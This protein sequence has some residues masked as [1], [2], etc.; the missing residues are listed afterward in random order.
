MNRH[1]F[2]RFLHIKNNSIVPFDEKNKGN[3][4]GGKVYFLTFGGQ[5]ISNPKFNSRNNVNYFKAVERICK[6]AKEF[7]IFYKIIGL[8]ESY[9]KEDNTF[10]NNHN[11]FILQNERGYGLWIWK[12]YIIKK[13]LEKMT[14]ND[15]LVYADSGCI[16]NINGKDRM[17]EYIEMSKE[18]KSGIVC[19][20]LSQ[21]EHE[22]TKMDIFNYLNAT[23]LL[24][25]KQ[26]IGCIS[27]I[28]KCSESIEII[29]KWYNLC[30]IYNLLDNSD[31][32]SK[33]SE[34]FVEHK[35]D[36]SIWSLIIKQNNNSI[37][38]DDETYF[39]DWEKDGNLF[40]IWA[41]RKRHD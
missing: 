12:P 27:I 2:Q 16:L 37:I 19:F 28:R 34:S 40:P 30:C 6:E 25:T 39:K 11:K 26:L 15:I 33:N 17:N 31:S 10:W 29:N 23:D 4:G 14:E 13:Q 9:L 38:L 1:N 21:I 8:T 7:S 41:K 22:W 3:V 5:F 36:Q 20:Q 24:E 18:S 35:N 32:I